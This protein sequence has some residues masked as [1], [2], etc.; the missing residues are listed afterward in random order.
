[1]IGLHDIFSIQGLKKISALL[2]CEYSKGWVG[3]KPWANV[4]KEV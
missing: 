2:T 4:V 1:V 3:G